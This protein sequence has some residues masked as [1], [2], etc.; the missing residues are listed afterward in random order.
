MSVSVLLADDHAVV[1]AGLIRLLEDSPDIEVVGEAGDGHEALR[2]VR[3]LQPD[4]VVM[5]L[6]M[7]GLDGIEATKHIVSEQLKTRVLILTMYT[8]EEYAVRLLQAGAR[9]F[10]GKGS[11]G[12]E[13]VAAIRKVAVGKTYLPAEL[14]EK[15]S[16]RFARKGTQ[17]AS[18]ETLS[19]REL[20]VLKRIAEGVTN[21]EVAKELHLS[22]KTVETYRARMLAK[23][24][25]QTTA[26][27][28]RFALRNGV[29]TDFGDRSPE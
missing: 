9:G 3:T 24:S 15:L 7:P 2:Q 18:L 28:V 4:V 25:L 16:D 17:T 21:Q 26:D 8:H 1:R 23:L 6:S 19:D 12:Q 29:V 5:D 11:L 20:Q 22:V 27:L 14:A 13:I 10:V